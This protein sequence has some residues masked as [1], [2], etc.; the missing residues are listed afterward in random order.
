[1]KRWSEGHGV[2]DKFTVVG[3]GQDDHFE[4][5]AVG[6]AD[7][8]VNRSGSS[9][10]ERDYGWFVALAGDR[11]GPVTAVKAKIIEVGVACLADPEPVHA[12]QDCQRGVLTVNAFRGE[13]EQS[14]FG[15]DEPVTLRWM[16]FENDFCVT[17]TN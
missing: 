9:W 15:A 7:G 14:E 1:M 3:E 2:D 4:E 10:D 13:Q 12:K 8:Q 6:R 17:R 5:L 16:N 11:Q